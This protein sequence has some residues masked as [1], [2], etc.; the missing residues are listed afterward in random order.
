MNFVIVYFSDGFAS[1]A[2]PVSC[3]SVSVANSPSQ[4]AIIIRT[5]PLAHTCTQRCTNQRSASNQGQRRAIK[6]SM[7]Y[8]EV[9]AQSVRPKDIAMNQS[10]PNNTEALLSHTTQP[11]C[12]LTRLQHRLPKPHHSMCEPL[13]RDYYRAHTA[14]KRGHTTP[15]HQ[16][17]SRSGSFLR[18]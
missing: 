6:H 11:H 14:F 1:E 12:S 8:S 13:I 5:P 15:S 4:I 17:T 9:D 10:S 18:S 2:T 7:L 16:Q 3:Y